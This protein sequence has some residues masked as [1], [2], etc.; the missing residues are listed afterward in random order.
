MGV[1]F[2]ALRYPVDRLGGL[3]V[4]FLGKAADLVAVLLVAGIGWSIARRRR[5]HAMASLRDYRASWYALRPPADR[6][7]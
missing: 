3:P 1:A 6:A 5:R 7:F 2:W 4:V